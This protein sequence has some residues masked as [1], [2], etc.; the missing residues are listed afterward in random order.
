MHK[1]MIGKVKPASADGTMHQENNKAMD[2]GWSELLE[3]VN[4]NLCRT[5][6]S[7]QVKMGVKLI[8]LS[9]HV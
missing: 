4:K 2:L 7:Y 5:H 1:H 8:T 6:E 3:M 9:M